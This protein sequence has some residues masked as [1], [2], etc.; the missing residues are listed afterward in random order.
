MRVQGVGELTDA[1][2]YWRLVYDDCGHVQA[3][4]RE[5]LDDPEGAVFFVRRH[6]AKCLTCTLADRPVAAETPNVDPDQVHLVL[7]A[8]E[9]G[10]IV[11]ALRSSDRPELADRLNKVLRQL[12]Q[13]R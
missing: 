5:G 6:Y 8:D 2:S 13:A 1:G 4:A 11:S 3:L 12:G 10:V 9:L 7:S